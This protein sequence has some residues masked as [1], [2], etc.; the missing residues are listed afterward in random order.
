MA[1]GVT[2]ISCSPYHTIIRNGN[3]I[4][5]EKYC[6][7]YDTKERCGYMDRDHCLEYERSEYTNLCSSEY[8]CE[9]VTFC[10]EYDTK[11]VSLEK[12]L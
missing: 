8:K 4:C 5:V 6:A 7:E 12:C 2:S 1:M 9:N 10:K 11:T 3:K